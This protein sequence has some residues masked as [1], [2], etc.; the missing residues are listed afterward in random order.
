M[1]YVEKERE[2]VCERERDR[3]CVCLFVRVRESAS[4]MHILDH[5]CVSMNV[6]TAN[7]RCE[8]VM[9]GFQDRPPNES[10]PTPFITNLR[11]I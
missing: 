4:I 5:E 10:Y 11:P 6:R 8:N 1:I 7:E 3:E 2:C 9:W